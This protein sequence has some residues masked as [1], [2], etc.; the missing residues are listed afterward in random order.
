MASILSTTFDKRRDQMFPSLDPIEI[1]RIRRFGERKVFEKG[2]SLA[3]SGER[4]GG[5]YI[6]LSGIVEIARRLPT[7]GRERITL[8]GAGSFFGELAQLADKPSL[9]DAV[10]LDDVEAL[11]LAPERMRSVL[12]AE[13]ELGERMMRAMILRRVGLLE[14]GTSGPVVIGRADGADELRLASFLRRNGHPHQLLDVDTDDEAATLI[15][16]FHIERGMLPIVICPGG[17]VLRNPSEDELARCIG[18]LSGIDAS[19]LYDVVVVGAG[20]AGLAAAVYAGSEGLSVLVLDCRSFGG[21]AGASARIE[22]YLGFPTGISGLALMARAYT[23]AHK[24]GVEIAI[25][26][27]AAALERLENGEFSLRLVNDECV[28][29]RSVI[30]ASGARY[31]SL[32]VTNISNFE[33]SSVHYWVSPLEAKMVK[34]QEIVLV[35]AGNSAGQAIV[36]LAGYARKVWMI[37]RGEGLGAS[38]SRYLIDR[39]E[40]Q[41]NIEVVTNSVVSH[42]SGH[43]GIL[44]TLGWRSNAG[45]ETQR[46]IRH[47]FLFIGAEPN[48]DWLAPT[49]ISR[50]AHGFLLTGDTAGAGRERLETSI[51][52]IFAIGDVR[53]GSIKRVAAAVGEG[54]EVV[55]DLHRYLAAKRSGD[56][57]S[58]RPVVR[59]SL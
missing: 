44:D 38:M 24:F 47:L 4:T 23:Q 10:S 54:A 33:A 32:P 56:G 40:S 3:R 13:A 21:Q 20:P 48:T 53:S 46:A 22:N 15:D 11:L 1:E 27:E 52:G 12:I 42:L 58:L 49:G 2:Q 34:D 50:D 35:G 17:Q 31:R 26:E 29:A 57:A 36:Y 41:P 51:S 19:R 16:K 30:I 7:G 45:A 5:F 9:V 28:R 39:I 43:D 6:I 59:A 8:Y 18:L 25:P 14:L 37:V 55:A